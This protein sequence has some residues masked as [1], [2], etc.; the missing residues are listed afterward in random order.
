[1]RDIFKILKHE[2]HNVKIVKNGGNFLLGCETCGETLYSIKEDFNAKSFLEA[3]Q[4]I[5][6]EGYTALQLQMQELV[7]KYIYNLS[8]DTQIGIVFKSTNESIENHI[9]YSYNPRHAFREFNVKVMVRDIMQRDLDCSTY[10]AIKVY[11]ILDEETRKEIAKEV[12]STI[13]KR[14]D[15]DKFILLKAG[16]KASYSYNT[17]EVKISEYDKVMFLFKEI[18]EK[19][20]QENPAPTDIIKVANNELYDIIPTYD[21]EECEN[22]EYCE[23][24]Y[25]MENGLYDFSEVE[26]STILRELIDLLEGWD[27][28]HRYELIAEVLLKRLG[29]VR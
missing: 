24:K 12:I 20:E 10:E 1:M 29:H 15:N 28:Y 13:E 16:E 22:Q 6:D 2:G 4:T 25:R 19:A 17:Y 5:T 3:Y 14:I 7:K 8:L 11:E 26:N 21:D 18:L 9:K 27:Y 23:Y